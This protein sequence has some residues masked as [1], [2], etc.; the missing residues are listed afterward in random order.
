MRGKRL[1]FICAEPFAY[2]V[3]HLNDE[4]PSHGHSAAGLAYSFVHNDLQGYR[5]PSSSLK[6]SSL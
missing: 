1:L 3:V 2:L 5:H 6:Q 4:S